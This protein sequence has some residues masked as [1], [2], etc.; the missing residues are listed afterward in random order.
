MKTYTLQDDIADSLKDP[1]FRE[2]WEE[3]EVEYQIARSFI[4]E[5][6]KNNLSQ[7]QLAKKA[8]TTQ[9]VISR[10][11]TMQCNPSIALLK[12]VADVMGGNLQV[13]I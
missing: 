2:A 8:K 13:S 10:L 4:A 5:R 12:R 11:E 6:L 7:K 9:A 1:A 3:S